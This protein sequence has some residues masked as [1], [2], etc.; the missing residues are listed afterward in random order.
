MEIQQQTKT[1]VRKA[2][3]REQLNFELEHSFSSIFAF[4][5]SLR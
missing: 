2:Q 5:A 1:L 3:I 4:F